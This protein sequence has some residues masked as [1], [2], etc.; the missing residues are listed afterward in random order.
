M[1]KH[2]FKKKVLLDGTVKNIE[3]ADQ[4][5]ILVDHIPP[6]PLPR[7]GRPK[8]LPIKIAGVNVTGNGK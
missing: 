2:F 6:L 8:Y 4:P 1:P 3:P 7:L 5:L